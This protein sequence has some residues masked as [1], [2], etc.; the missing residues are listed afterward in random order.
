MAP[1]I[2]GG[3][4]IIGVAGG[5]YP[6]RGFFSAFD[7]MTGDEVWKFY[8]VPGDPSLG[9]ENDAMRMAAETWKRSTIR[10][11]S[12]WTGKVSGTISRNVNAPSAPMRAWLRPWLLLAGACSGDSLLLR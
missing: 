2:A 6:V 10:P 5:E 8:T 11:L 12:T 3:N 4:V 7:A 9:F 1:R